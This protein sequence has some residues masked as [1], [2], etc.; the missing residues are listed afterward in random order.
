MDSIFVTGATGYLGGYTCAR[1]LEL[2]RDRPLRLLVRCDSR[3]QA[4]RKLWKSWQLHMDLPTFSQAMRRVRIVPGDLHAPGL[5]L[6]EPTRAELVGATE[7]ILHIAASLNRKSEHA[8]LNTNLRGTL[9]VLTLAREIHEARGLRRFSFVSTVAVAGQREREIVPEDQSIQWDR[10]QY[11][12]YARTKAFSELMV[13]ELLPDVPITLFRPST[14]LGDSR[15]PRTTQWDMVRAFVFFADLPALPWGPSIRQDIVNADYVGDAIATIHLKDRP[16][17]TRYHLSAG[18]QSATTQQILRAMVEHTGQRGPRFASRLQTPFD[19][20]LRAL[21]ASLPKGAPQRIA[22]MLKVFLPYV[23]NDTVF[24]N[25]RVISE[26][27]RAPVPFT[28][29][30]ADLYRYAKA[31]DFRFP[32][33]DLPEGAVA[34]ILRET[35]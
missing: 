35:P 21:D 29:Y 28:T 30:C 2:E 9:S 10:R 5:G 6:P 7:S 8:C 24:D 33:Q 34:E 12:P 11:D 13:E 14:V 32:Y 22:G 27:G 17:F 23:T 4:V 25:G 19:Q 16:Q 15:H 3:E 31:Q 1:L 20:T 26:L 18:T